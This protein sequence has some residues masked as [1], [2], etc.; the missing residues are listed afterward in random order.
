MNKKNTIHIGKID[1]NGSG[2]RNCPVEIEI[3]LRGADTDKPELSISGTVW[4]PKHTDCYM[5]GQC[6]D[7]LMSYFPNNKVMAEIL[8][9]WT[10]YH[11]NGMHAGTIAQEKALHDAGLSN[12]ANE[13]DK[14]L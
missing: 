2:R 3:E 7:D 5:A 4:N 8:R 1:Y 10:L 13:Y 12:W 11:L 14:S 9:L 6:I